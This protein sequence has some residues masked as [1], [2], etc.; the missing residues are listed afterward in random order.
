VCVKAS[1]ITPPSKRS[2]GFCLYPPKGNK[3]ARRACIA[4]LKNTPISIKR[5]RRF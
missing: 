2:I 5:Q 4:N 3:V 1:L